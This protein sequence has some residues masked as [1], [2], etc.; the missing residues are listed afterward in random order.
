MYPTCTEALPF[1]LPE[2]HKYDDVPCAVR[3]G[4]TATSSLMMP[5][6]TTCPREWTMQYNGFLVSDES[7]IRLYMFA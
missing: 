7:R 1:H 5:A 4:N 6:K 2:F 3:H